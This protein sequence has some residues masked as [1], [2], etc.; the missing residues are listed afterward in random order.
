MFSVGF[1]FRCFGFDLDILV[2]V[3][4]PVGS[5]QAILLFVLDRM[6]KVLTV[7]MA[8]IP[9]VGALECCFEPMC[10]VRGE[11]NLKQKW[12]ISFKLAAGILVHIS[13]EM[14]WSS[15]ANLWQVQDRLVARNIGCH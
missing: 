13:R 6:A 4:F 5:A 3:P 9:D 15:K 1:E 2:L 10:R 8:S 14:P 11:T 12:Q 7:P